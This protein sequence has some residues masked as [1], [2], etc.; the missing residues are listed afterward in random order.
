MRVRKASS[1]KKEM[2]GILE[3]IFNKDIQTIQMG[4]LAA[5]MDKINNILALLEKQ[6][7]GKEEEQKIKDLK[8]TI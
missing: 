5:Q 6:E 3:N 8:K 4:M 2:D 7:R 1:F